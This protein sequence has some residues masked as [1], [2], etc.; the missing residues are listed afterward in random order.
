MAIVI[1]QRKRGKAGSPRRL[2]DSEYLGDCER[3]KN[4]RLQYNAWAASRVSRF[5]DM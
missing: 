2:F 5:E 4:E 1:G 3:S